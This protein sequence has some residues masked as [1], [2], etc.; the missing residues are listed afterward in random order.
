MS[1]VLNSW[2]AIGALLLLAIV[3]MAILAQFGLFE[4]ELS[5]PPV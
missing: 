4:H 1:K 5:N 2:W 3:V